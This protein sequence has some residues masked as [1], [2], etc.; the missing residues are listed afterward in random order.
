ME[1]ERISTILNELMAFDPSFKAHEEQIRTLILELETSQPKVLIDPAFKTGL[2]ARL[3]L[4]PAPLH[5]PFSTLLWYAFRLAPIGAVA[6]LIFTLTQPPPSYIQSVDP[7]TFETAPADP[8]LR[9]EG[10]TSA[11]S[12]SVPQSA[13]DGAVENDMYM[14]TE[15]AMNGKRGAEVTS[16]PSFPFIVPPQKEGVLAKI[17]SI[18]APAPLFIAIIASYPTGDEVIGASPLLNT[19]TT[20]N[21]PVYLKSRIV[22]EGS[23]RAEAY[24]DNGDRIFVWGEDPL[25]TDDNGYAWSVPLEVAIQ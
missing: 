22:G 12:L 4:L 13:E 6:L 14:Q 9:Y 20:E 7:A 5:T 3:M 21:I 10:G 11:E 19:G 16:S 24:R 25:I 1:R 18:T 2:R 15:S 17:T 23:Y 8:T